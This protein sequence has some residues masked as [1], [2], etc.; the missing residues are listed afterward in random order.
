MGAATG[1]SK[2]DAILELVEN[3][4][5]GISREDA[6]A[7]M[8]RGDLPSLLQ[9]AG[10]IRD[11]FHGRTI[12]YSKKVFIPLTRLC[13]DYCGYCTFRR[14]PGEPGGRFM[15]PDEVLGLAEK[16]KRA[17]CKEALFSLGDQPERLF[18]KAAEELRKLGYSRTLEYGI[19]V[20]GAIPW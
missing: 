7:L 6:L 17:G 8:M 12:S 5:D 9:A 2:A 3:F 18:P 10:A 11:R 16:G 4:S 19:G 1:S 20:L 13:R 14:D 15:T